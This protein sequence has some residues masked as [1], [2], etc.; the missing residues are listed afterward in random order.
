MTL[1]VLF[2][3]ISSVVLKMISIFSQEKFLLINK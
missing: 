3:K 1:E 2:E